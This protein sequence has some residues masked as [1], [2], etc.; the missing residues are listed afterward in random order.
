MFRVATDKRLVALSFD[1]GPDPAYTPSVLRNLHQSGARATFFLVGVNAVAHRGLVAELT[2][3]GHTIGNH[4]YDHRELELLAPAAVDLEIEKGSAAIVS[5]GGQLPKLF[6]PPRGFTDEVV[7]IEARRDRYRTVFWTLC[8]EHF[9]MTYGLS[10]GVEAML[11]EVRPGAVLLAHDGGRIE[12][13]GRR[14]IDRRETLEALP[15]LLSGLA[16]KRLR[17]VDV[18]TLLRHARPPS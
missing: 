6:R 7:R 11:D 14:P 3:A 9:V 8:L 16:A 4:T 17:V 15:L 5:A 18:P 10:G 1:D 2:S 13:S 12:G